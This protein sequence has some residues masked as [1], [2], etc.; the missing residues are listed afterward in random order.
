MTKL[1]LVACLF[2][3]AC[4]S[5]KT[6]SYI[7][8]TGEASSVQQA[9]ELAFREAIQIKVGA[10]V[11]SERESNI[12]KILRDDVSLYSAGYVED[13]KIVSTERTGGK[14]RVTVDVLVS[15]SV[16]M[17]QYTNTGKDSKF[18]NGERDSAR[19]GSFMEHKRQADR[20]IKS[21]MQSYPKTAFTIK[22]YPYT[23]QV[24]SNR[25]GLLTVPYEMHWNKDFIKSFNEAMQHTL[26]NKYG[27]LEKSPANVITMTKFSDDT[28]L[29]TKKHFKFNDVVLLNNIK[30]QMTGSKEVRIM[31]RVTDASGKPIHV[32]CWVPRSVNGSKNSFYG[33]GEPSQLTIY[34]NESERGHLTVVIPSNLTSL[35]GRANSVELSVVAQQSCV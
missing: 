33:I 17:N 34:G 26:D 23:V 10:V 24:D 9:Q 8:T 31:L 16:L 6:N 15:D 14:V 4:A 22:Q 5:T 7:R 3:T 32:N 27:I 28:V 11:V 30:D 25:N 21:V 12:H 29:G 2:L 1:L 18:I 35:L 19:L 20:L 13:F